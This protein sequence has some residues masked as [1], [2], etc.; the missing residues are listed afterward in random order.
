MLQIVA[1]TGSTNADLA[2]RLR[3][4]EPVAEGTWLI[5]DRQTA[6]RGRLGRLWSDGAGNFMGSTVVWPGGG[7]PHAGSLALV[8]GLATQAAVA[9]YVLPPQ[10]PLL[11][12]PNDVMVGAAK[13]AGILLERVGDA[14]IVGIG[15]NLIQAPE[16]PGRATVCLSA[17][18][19]AP[20]R[21]GFACALS[22]HMAAQV[23]AWRQ[24]GLG[25]LL[26]RW[27]VAAHP[28]GTSLSVQ[29]PDGSILNGQFA[30][31]DATGALRLSLADGRVHTV[32]AGDVALA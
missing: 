24:H 29:Q 1:E 12:W 27:Q 32:H 21:D 30:G 31:L 20:D 25:A 22:E 2:E 23:Q 9:P 28:H 7:D 3:A 11:K 15:V 10:M 4:G 13:L 17:F 8:A 19:P 26:S 16:I 14:V 5:A 18:G 6:G